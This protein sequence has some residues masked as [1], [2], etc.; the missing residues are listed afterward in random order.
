MLYVV[1]GKQ[2]IIFLWLRT[3]LFRSVNY[4]VIA[5]I[6]I[7]QYFSFHILS[8]VF[9]GLLKEVSLL[10]IFHNKQKLVGKLEPSVFYKLNVS[11]RDP[12]RMYVPERRGILLK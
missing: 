7:V 3:R 2:L 12:Y 10:P 5:F 1:R 6:P 8:L 9:L 11:I 4:S